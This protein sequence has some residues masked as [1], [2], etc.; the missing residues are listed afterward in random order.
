MEIVANGGLRL[1]K[2]E[3]DVTNFEINLKSAKQIWRA[4]NSLRAVYHDLYGKMETSCRPGTILEIGAGIGNLKEY[5]SNAVTIDVQ[6]VPWID[7]VADGECLP[8]KDNCFDNILIFDVLHHIG[9]V[10]RFFLEVGRVLSDGGMVVLV[11][12]AI[13][14]FS[15]FFYKRFHPEP[16]DLDVDPLLRAEVGAALD[17]LKA[18]QGIPTLLFK[19][20]RR[21]FE[22]AFPT[23]SIKSVSWLSLFAF[24]MSGGF[25]P[26]SLLP[27]WLVTPLL[28]IEDA[29]LPALGRFMAF[30]IMVV[31]ERVNR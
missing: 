13:T 23:L 17:P 26:W 24:P 15:G 10:K 29:L 9:N 18:N 30:R 11:E 6:T 5:F 22:A 28:F 7:V 20:H 21:E 16:F 1:Q 31:L 3:I 2:T 14:P 19:H 12:P 25:R 4:K 8:F 27:N